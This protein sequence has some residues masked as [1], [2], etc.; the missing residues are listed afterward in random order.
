[1]EKNRCPLC[2][3]ENHC[4]VAKGQKECWCM[5]ESFPEKIFEELTQKQNKCIC[6]KCL[7]TYKDI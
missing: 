5:T 3:K 4:G 1:M 6:Q 2:R 7:D